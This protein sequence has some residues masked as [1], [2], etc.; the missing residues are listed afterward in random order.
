MKQ[1]NFNIFSNVLLVLLDNIL[2]MKCIYVLLTNG[3]L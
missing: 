2:V 1:Y 3:L